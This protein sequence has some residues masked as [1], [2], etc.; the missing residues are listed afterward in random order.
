MIAA[1]AAAAAA[2]ASAANRGAGSARIAGSRLKSASEP[3]ESTPSVSTTGTAACRSVPSKESRLSGRITTTRGSASVR[4]YSSSGGV[5]AA[6][7]GTK[8]APMRR[9]ATYSNTA[10]ADLSICAATRSPQCTPRCL[11]AAAKRAEATSSS[12]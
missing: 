12:P 9:Q 7:N 6:P 4:K 11:K 1:T 5:L 8:T 3:F 2:P 10:S